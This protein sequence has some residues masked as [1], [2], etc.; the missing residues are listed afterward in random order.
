MDSVKIIK[1]HADHRAAMDRIAQLMDLNPTPGSDDAL[2][3]DA[4]AVLVEAYESREGFFAI[5]EPVTPLEVI[6]FRMEQN[7]LTPKD[8]IS[9][10]GSK[11][12][13]SEVLSGK[14][15]LSLTMIKKLHHGLHIPAE[16]LLDVHPH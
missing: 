13:V 10:L 4:L 8:M 6:K 2:E 14:R 11:S 5:T 7:G 1:N 16:L 15:G 12:K 9:Y 3:L